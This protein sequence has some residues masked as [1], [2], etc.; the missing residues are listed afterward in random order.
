M[1]Q[2]IMV[3][4]L[5]GLL[6]SPA[7]ADNTDTAQAQAN[8]L[9][10]AMAS[11]DFTTVAQLTHPS[12]VRAMGGNEALA[13]ELKKVFANGKVDITEMVFAKPSQINSSGKVV[14]AR[15]PYHSKATISGEIMDVDSYYV[16]FSVNKTS[17]YFLDCEGITQD[18]LRQLSSG[19]DGKLKLEG[20]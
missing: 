18:L 4:L 17:W 15:M 16:G 5:S 11:E 20:C 13:A 8:K 1:K 2:T 12:V 9:G 19:Y 7:L 10:T 14:L 6:L 3:M